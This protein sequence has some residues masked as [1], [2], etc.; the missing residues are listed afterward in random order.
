MDASQLNNIKPDQEKR[1][2]YYESTMRWIEDT[3]LKWF[4]ENRTSYGIK[5]TF[6]AL[7]F[8]LASFRSSLDDG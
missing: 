2:T 8:P 5:G 3:Y 1:N 4:G 6:P 7:S